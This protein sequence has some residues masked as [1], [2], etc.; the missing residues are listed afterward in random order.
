MEGMLTE[1]RTAVEL[2]VSPGRRTSF[3]GGDGHEQD[4][5]NAGLGD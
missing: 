2:V 3:S 5:Q 1:L 4:E